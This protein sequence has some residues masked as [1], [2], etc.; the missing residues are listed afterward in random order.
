P[1]AWFSWPASARLSLD[2]MVAICCP[3]Q[4]SGTF[5]EGRPH[6]LESPE[7]EPASQGIRPTVS[8]AL[9]SA[10]STAVSP[11]S[12]VHRANTDV[13]SLVQSGTDWPGRC[14]SMVALAPK[15][16]QGADTFAA[17]HV[18]VRAAWTRGPPPAQ[19]EPT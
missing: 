15:A 11:R 14:H 18:R 8:T 16:M 2:G 6:C 3:P 17:H 12:V 13:A 5:G 10:R 9:Q 7:Y 19:R 4:G 1:G